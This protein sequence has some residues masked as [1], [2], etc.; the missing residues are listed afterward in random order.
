M[1]FLRLFTNSLLAGALG[2]AYLT[3]LLLQLNPEVPLV[4]R[5]VWRWY[6]T[7]GV[8]YGVHLA[9]LFY[10]TMLLREFA[11]VEIFSP[12]WISVRLLAWLS[13]AA[14]AVAATLMWLNLN[15]FPTLF[16]EPAARRFAFGA[17]ATT[18]SA[19]VLLG[20]AV[21]HYSFGRRGSRVGAALLVIAITGSLA[22]PIAARGLGGPL[23][24]GARRVM[25][26]PPPPRQSPHVTLLLLDGASLEYV[27]PRVAA[28]RLPNFGR[29]LDAGASM[30]LAT[31]RPTQPDPVWA[32]VATGMYP[33]KNGV[34][35]AAS[36]FARGDDR[37]VDLLPDHCFSH[38][39]VRLGVVR[40][41]PNSSAAWR[42]RPLWAILGDYGLSAGIV[43]WPLTYPALPITG[44]LVTD[45]FHQLIGSMIEADDRAVYP[46]DVLEPAR[47][48]FAGSSGTMQW[49]EFY[50]R[51]ARDVSAQHPVGLEAVRYQGLDIAGHRYLRYAQPRAFGDVSDEER[52]QLGAI[53]ERAYGAIDAEIGAAIGRQA[54]GDLLL[55][56]SGFGMQPVNPVKRLAARMLRDPDVTGTHENAPDGF[57][58][59]YGTPVAAGR[60][61][62]GSIVDVTPTILYF[63]G[64]PLGRDMDGYARADLFTRDFTAERPI[65]FI[66]SHGR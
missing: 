54:P 44:F 59:A 63:L 13:A 51:A 38:I 39:L 30:D 12:G 50:G 49:D 56:V 64:V 31:I 8:F 32:A 27:W 36:Y 10:V 11:S 43:R 42:A 52:Q 29:V 19:L 26:V 37:P 25:L 53:L 18:A 28:G 57:V 33:A 6:A 24:L 62:R 58:L 21:A 7:L 23:P 34:R 5:T 40:D 3:I 46:L 1:R 66:P 20:I 16:D 15:G 45:R 41:R 60:K 14:A 48:A 4:S 2:A 22:L 55:V 35:S 61:Q 65:T 9:I 17:G 47:D